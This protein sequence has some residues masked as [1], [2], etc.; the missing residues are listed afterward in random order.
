VWPFV[1]WTLGDLNLERGILNVTVN[2]TASEN[3]NLGGGSFNDLPGAGIQAA[4]GV[5]DA[6]DIPD[7]DVAPYNGGGLSCGF[8]DTPASGS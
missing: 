5:F 3:A 1:K 8:V 4:Y 7:V 6:D 2:G